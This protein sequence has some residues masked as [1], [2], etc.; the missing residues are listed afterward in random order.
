[1]PSDKTQTK[2]NAAWKRNLPRIQAQLHRLPKPAMPSHSPSIKG[3]VGMT[4]TYFIPMLEYRSGQPIMDSHTE[5]RIGLAPIGGRGDAVYFGREIIKT[6]IE[7]M[8]GFKPTMRTFGAVVNVYWVWRGKKEMIKDAND[9]ERF[10]RIWELAHVI[11]P[12][13]TP[14]PK[15]IEW[16][17]LE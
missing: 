6:R 5:E 11:K 3:E 1:M 13:S 7:T 8:E 9:N 10:I 12:R 15:G 4:T 16:Q 17:G 14:L 2:M